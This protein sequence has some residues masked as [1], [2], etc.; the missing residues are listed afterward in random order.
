MKLS[1]ID[2]IVSENPSDMTSIC[3]IELNSDMLLG[4]YMTYIDTKYLGGFKV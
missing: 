1:F 2:M 4:M 3:F